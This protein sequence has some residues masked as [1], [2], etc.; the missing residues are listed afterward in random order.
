MMMDT[1]LTGGQK[2]LR[3]I[4]TVVLMIPIFLIVA[5]AAQRISTTIAVP[6]ALTLVAGVHYGVGWLIQRVSRKPEMK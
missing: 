2:A 1:Q 4:I 5:A 6:V 3:F